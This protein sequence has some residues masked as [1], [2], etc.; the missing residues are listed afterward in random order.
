MRLSRCSRS[1]YH[2]SLGLRMKPSAFSILTLSRILLLPKSPTH[3]VLGCRS[4]SGESA[5]E[6]LDTGDHKPRFGARNRCLEVFCK[7]TVAVEPGDG[8][9]D[10]PAAWQQFEAFGGIGSF[11]D[12][13]GPAAD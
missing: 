6:Q 13:D 1:S 11:D 8:S 10:D 12:L 7:T 2:L 5:R 4:C 3:N 9:F